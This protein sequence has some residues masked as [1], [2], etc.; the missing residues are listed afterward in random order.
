MIR[1]LKSGDLLYSLALEELHRAL[2]LLGWA[3]RVRGSTFR[4]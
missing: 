4:G 1:K 3:R 2:V